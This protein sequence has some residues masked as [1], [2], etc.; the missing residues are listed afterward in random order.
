LATSEDS[1]WSA[2]FHAVETALAGGGEYVRRVLVDRRRRDARVRRLLE[3][4]ER[5][6][7]AV[8][9]VSQQHLDAC[10]PG[11]RHQGVCAELVG[12]RVFDEQA[13]ARQVERL[14][15][16]LVLV[17]D[18]V[19]DPHNLGACLRSAEAAG[20]DVVVVARDRAARVTAVVERSAAGAAS[21]V[22]LAAVTNLGRTLER[23]KGLGCWAVGMAGEAQT[24]LFDIDLTGPLALV[25]GAEDHGLRA[26]TRGACDC[27]ASIPLA[28]DL[29]SLNVSVATGVCLFE[30]VRQQRA[31]AGH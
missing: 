1:N 29:A 14:T 22:P 5:V 8:E 9:R 20:A 13:L 4:A 12:D 18:R 7:V 25:V 24:G 15:E 26:R 23:L 3:R 19:R 28:G 11:A 21:R 17:L 31:T 16:P 6:G 27:L 30:R 2:G 10:V